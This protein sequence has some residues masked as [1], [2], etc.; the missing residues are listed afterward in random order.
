MGE[1]YNPAVVRSYMVYARACMVVLHMLS[2]LR[3]KV[4]IC[5]ERCIRVVRR[6]PWNTMYVVMLFMYA[7]PPREF[8]GNYYA[9]TTHVILCV[10]GY[11]CLCGLC[12]TVQM[13]VTYRKGVHVCTSN[14]GFC[15]VYILCMWYLSGK[16]WL[17][18]WQSS[19]YYVEYIYT[20][21]V[22]DKYGVFMIYRHYI[23]CWDLSF[24]C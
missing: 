16:V 23:L 8:Y 17:S 14:H 24:V 12:C 7:T 21:R 2:S 4:H 11:V 19:D 5:T 3:Y 15:F 18:L 9:Y 1:H 6:I 13:T 22:T 20:Q 10:A